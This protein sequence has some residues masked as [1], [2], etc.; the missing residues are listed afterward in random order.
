MLVFFSL[1]VHGQNEP[2]YKLDSIVNSNGIKKM[3]FAYE[4]GRVIEKLDYTRSMD[5]FPDV[6]R[7]TRYEYDHQGRILLEDS[8]GWGG[9][10][11]IH[12]MKKEFTYDTEGHLIT[13]MLHFKSIEDPEFSPLQKGEFIYETGNLVSEFVFYWD[14]ESDC[15]DTTAIYEYEYDNDGNLLRYFTTRGSNK[16]KEDFFYDESGNKTT[17]I[18]QQW[19]FD[20]NN[21]TNYIKQECSYDEFGNLLSVA[22]YIWS[23]QNGDWQYKKKNEFEYNTEVP[24][25][26]LIVPHD[27]S[28][29]YQLSY[30][31]DY[32]MGVRWDYHYSVFQELGMKGFEA[33]QVT[34]FPNP[35]TDR[36]ILH[37]PCNVKNPVLEIFDLQGKRVMHR[38]Y[39]G[40]YIHFSVKEFI[41]G[42]YIYRLKTE[43]EVYQGKIIKS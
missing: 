13:E 14:A 43:N 32:G 39:S 17:M 27:Y 42:I 4:E 31:I 38:V 2:L 20:Q 35:A 9:E 23:A 3:T 8:Y 34:A 18:G 21:W 10:N 37:I 12:V 19:D 15:W 6:I 7:K 22:V 28:W 16:L 26:L 30:E 41:P 11:W 24:K 1:S 33:Q 40:D 29:D 25:S 36:V 5:P